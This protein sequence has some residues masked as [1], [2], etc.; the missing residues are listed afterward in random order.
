MI[1]YRVPGS[2]ITLAYTNRF[3]GINLDLTVILLKA[4]RIYVS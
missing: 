2:T 3:V 1:R 4:T